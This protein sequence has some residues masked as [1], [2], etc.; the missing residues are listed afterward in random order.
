MEDKGGDSRAGLQKLRRV[1]NSSRA[2]HINGRSAT[3]D[4]RGQLRLKVRDNVPLAI[5]EPW[6][7]PG[8]AG[9]GELKGAVQRD[10]HQNVFAANLRQRPGDR[11]GWREEQQ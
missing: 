10:T 9:G 2:A 7:G 1:L 4:K 8:A 3:K 5:K 11:Q 6:T